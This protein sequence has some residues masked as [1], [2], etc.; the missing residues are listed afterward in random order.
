MQVRSLL[1]AL[2]CQQKLT[3]WRK[4]QFYTRSLMTN[5]VSDAIMGIEK[6]D[7]RSGKVRLCCRYIRKISEVYIARMIF[8]ELLCRQQIKLNGLIRHALRRPD[9]VDIW[10]QE[11]LCV[12]WCNQI[13]QSINCLDSRLSEKDRRFF[14]VNPAYRPHAKEKSL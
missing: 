6:Q 9:Q 2:S 10:D 7:H 11:Y 13:N 4:N 12:H 8:R 14:C 5:P 3:I 1:S